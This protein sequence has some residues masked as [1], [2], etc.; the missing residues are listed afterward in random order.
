[1]KRKIEIFSGSD[2]GTLRNQINLFLE[3]NQNLIKEVISVTLSSTGYFHTI[4]LMYS[5]VE[6]ES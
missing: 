6:T 2:N 1:M 3:Q 4:V 5:L